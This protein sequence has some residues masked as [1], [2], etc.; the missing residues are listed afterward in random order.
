L[1][2]LDCEEYSIAY[3]HLIRR[4]VERINTS[5]KEEEK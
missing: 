4:T 5:Q 1:A 3:K 2:S